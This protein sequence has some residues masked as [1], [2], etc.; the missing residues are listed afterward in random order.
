MKYTMT[1]FPRVSRRIKAMYIYHWSEASTSEAF[2]SGLIDKFGKPRPAY[3][4]F[5]KYLKR[6]APQ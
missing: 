3:F 2:D 4:T 6:K 1:K 5:F